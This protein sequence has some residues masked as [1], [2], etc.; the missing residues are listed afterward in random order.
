MILSIPRPHTFLFA[1]AVLGCAVRTSRPAWLVPDL[2][3]ATI[4][5]HAAGVT[6]LWASDAGVLEAYRVTYRPAFA[7]PTSMWIERRST[8]ITMRARAPDAASSPFPRLRSGQRTSSDEDWERLQFYLV[9]GDV[10][11]QG[12]ANAEPGCNW[13]LDG[14]SWQFEGYRAPQEYVV[15]TRFCPDVYLSGLAEFLG[16]IG[17]RPS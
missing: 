9:G 15:F 17:S 11:H 12:I 6:P 14:E 10:W 7:K 8:G 13:P 16:V 5:S 3:D 2:Y 4:S 1:V